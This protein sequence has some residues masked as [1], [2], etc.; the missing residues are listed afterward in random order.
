V[1]I[2]LQKHEANQKIQ[3]YWHPNPDALKRGNFMSKIVVA[4][5][6]NALGDT[7]QEQ[8]E[9]AKFAAKAIC[10]LIVAG[11]HVVIAHGNGPQVGRILLGLPEMPFAEATAMSQGY[12]GYHLQQSIDEEMVARGFDEVPVIAMLTQVVVDNADPAFQRPTKPVGKFFS[13]AEAKEIMARTGYVY[14][15]DAGRGWRRVVPSPAPIDIYEKITLKTLLDAGQVVIACGGG[16]IP[17]VYKG[18]RYEG[19]DAVIDKDFAA[20]KLAQLVE[21]DIFLILTAVDRVLI[22]FRKPNERAVE[23]MTVAEAREYIAEG[24]FAPGS[25]LPKVQAACNFAETGGTSI[26][27]SLEKAEAALSGA[28]G[29]VVVK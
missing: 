21:A 25:M 24:H 2:W 13:E 15:E 19:V 23:K 14:A 12:I 16:G 17:V 8:L 11:H 1:N 26:I 20:A 10:D 27:T 9:K 22:N 3:K 5:G 6:G 4:L 7:P 28:V 18:T 29:T